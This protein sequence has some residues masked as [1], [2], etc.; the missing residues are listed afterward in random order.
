MVNMPAYEITLISH[1]LIFLLQNK[2]RFILSTI[3]QCTR[4]HVSECTMS[5]WVCECAREKIP[6]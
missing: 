5:G 4:I 3:I 2:D 1:I 6:L